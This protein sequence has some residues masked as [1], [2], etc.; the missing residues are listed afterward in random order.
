MSNY[1]LSEA[2]YALPERIIIKRRK[3]LFVPIAMLLI[4][5]ALLVAN[6]ML[7]S[8]ADLDTLRSALILFGG[9][10]ACVGVVMLFLRFTDSGFDPYHKDDRCFLK[11]EELKFQ[12]EQKTTVLDLLSKQDFTTLRNIPSDGISALIVV[13]YSS[14]KGS[15]VAAQAFEYIDLELTPVSRLEVKP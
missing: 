12:K 9:C 6:S 8:S 10:F 7:H 4:G 15:F 3:S 11:R 5:S 13:L 14:P 1:K 2:L